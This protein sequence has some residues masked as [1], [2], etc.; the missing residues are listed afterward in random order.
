MNY[1]IVAFA[2]DE[3]K[4]WLH[5]FAATSLNDVKDKVFDYII[6]MYD[7]NE[8]VPMEWESF[9]EFCRKEEIYIGQIEEIT[10]YV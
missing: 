2:D 8:K 5:K 4:P 6:D 7:F 9:I 3:L 1:Y 10:N